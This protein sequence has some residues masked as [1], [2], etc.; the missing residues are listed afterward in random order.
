[1]NHWLMGVAMIFLAAAQMQ[2][3]ARKSPLSYFLFG[4]AVVLAILHF[5]KDSGV[6]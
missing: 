3:I 2:G 4:I 6:L 5:S 1:M